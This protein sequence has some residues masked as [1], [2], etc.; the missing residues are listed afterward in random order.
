MIK[1]D[2]IF[3]VKASDDDNRTIEGVFSTSDVDRS[4]DPPIEQESWN[5]KNF[6]KNPVVLFA[7]DNHQ[8]PVG[9]VTK[10][11]F[12][13]K[14]NLAGKIR[15]AIDEGV[16]VYGDL[17]KTIYNLYKGKFMR[18]FS[19]GF[20][21]GDITK[22]K[23]GVK[24]VNN[25]LLEI[26]CVPVP[27]NALALAKSKGIDLEPLEKMEEIE[28]E[29]DDVINYNYKTEESNEDVKEE[30]EEKEKETEEETAEVEEENN[31]SEEETE[32][33]EEE[34]DTKKNLSNKDKKVV[35]E[36]S[37]KRKEKSTMRS[38]NKIIRTLL[39]ERREIKNKR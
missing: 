31:E 36:C 39:A 30:I 33:T 32:D 14:G 19:V 23:K 27:A 7:H 6:K 16:G 20:S 22:D 29:I 34:E 26:S 4:G 17:I 35:T 11:N 13:E 1:K 12:N 24:M 10:L 3:D 21:M 9:Q 15:F 18:A 28:D 25:E 38:L 2:F 37:D 8:I 5:L